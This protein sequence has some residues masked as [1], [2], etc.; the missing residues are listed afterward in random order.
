MARERRKWT[1]AE[2]ELLKAA[3]SQGNDN[4]KSAPTVSILRFGPN[5]THV[6]IYSFLP[7]FSPATF[8]KGLIH[9]SRF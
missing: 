6:I 4:I 3:V 5:L 2:D 1:A 9:S 8:N 7:S